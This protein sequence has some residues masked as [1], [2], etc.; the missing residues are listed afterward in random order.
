M[1]SFEL[2]LRTRIRFG[3]GELGRLGEEAAPL[4]RRALLVTGRSF[5][6]R[7]GLTDRAREL[8]EG[9]GLAVSVFDRVQP[10]PHTETADE[11]AAWAR[12][13]GC[14]L[15]V[16]LGGGSVMDAAKGI[17]VA[18]LG[19]A[20]AWDY[21]RGSERWQELYPIRRGLPLI[22]VPTLAGTGSEANGTAVLTRW[23]TREKTVMS[24]SALFPRVALVDPSLTVSVPAGTTADGA[25]DILIHLLEGYLTGSDT[26]DVQDRITEGLVAVVLEHGP[27]AF[28]DGRD[29]RS[30]TELS[31]ASTLALSGVPSLGRGGTFPL[32][33]LEHALSGHFDVSHGRGL[34]ALF[35]TYARRFRQVRPAR[36]ALLGWR[37]LGVTGDDEAV[38]RETVERL[39][40]WMADLGEPPGLASLGLDPGSFPSLAEEVIRLN[41]HGQDHLP[42]LP[43]LD[44]Q[45]VLD[46]YQAAYAAG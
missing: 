9:A 13:E 1:D 34:A 41:G 26:A 6:A 27:R 15:V 39:A 46:L 11:G 21:C 16:A 30:R 2:H 42:G 10:N 18:A 31:W 17:A 4:G 37:V 29:L 38:A 24:G 40:G 35:P 33:S 5:A 19:E 14:D 44:R 22:A 12:R 20:S 25:V 32:H 45:G 28:R 7:G 3:V 36:L 8:L 23:S 43:S